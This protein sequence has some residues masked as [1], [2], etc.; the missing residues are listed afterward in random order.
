[1]KEIK[2]SHA[3]FILI[4]TGAVFMLT[5][6]KFINKN[7]FVA[8]MVLF[9]L[10]DYALVKISKKKMDK[11][12]HDNFKKIGAGFLIFAVLA[13]VD[14]MMSLGEV[15][16]NNSVMHAGM[17]IIFNVVFYALIISTIFFTMKSAEKQSNGKVKNKGAKKV[18]NDHKVIEFNN[19]KKA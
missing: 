7:L 16:V 13:V 12:Q 19:R 10:A 1:M 5:S 8:F 2:N 3:I 15:F 6:F 9:I 4:V 11:R 18:P 17:L 14:K